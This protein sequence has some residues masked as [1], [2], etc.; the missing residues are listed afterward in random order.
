M[1][2][3]VT[4]LRRVTLG[5]QYLLQTIEIEDLIKRFLLDDLIGQS[6]L[7]QLEALDLV[8]DRALGD[9]AVGVDGVFLSDAMRSVD[10]LGF[11]GGIP[12]WVVE[13]DVGGGSE[14]K[15]GAGRPQGQEKGGDGFVFLELIDELL[16]VLGL[17]RQ[18]EVLAANRLQFAA[19]DFQHFHELAED[20]YLVSL[21]HELG[22]MIQEGFHLGALHVGVGGVDE[23]RMTANLA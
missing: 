14:I 7:L 6:F 17:A 13:N 2:V 22:N 18:H 11:H 12:P 19:N 4:A 1:K 15:P 16:S 23:A 5:S 21:V 9:D 8:F 10:R 20:E 3:W